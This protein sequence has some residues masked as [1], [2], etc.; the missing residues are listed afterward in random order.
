MITPLN[1]SAFALS[2]LTSDELNLEC[3]ERAIAGT[4]IEI[5]RLTA[6]IETLRNKQAR[7]NAEARAARRRIVRTQHTRPGSAASREKG[8][9][10]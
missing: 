2:G 5:A 10:S 7:R 4:D 1:P 6:T 8:G 3:L 9:A